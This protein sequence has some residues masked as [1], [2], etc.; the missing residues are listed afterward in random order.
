[1]NHDVFYFPQQELKKSLGDQLY[2]KH[3]KIIPLLLLIQYRLNS[4]FGNYNDKRLRIFEYDNFIFDL[5]SLLYNKTLTLAGYDNHDADK[6]YILL[7]R[8]IVNNSRYS[9]AYSWL[10]DNYDIAICDRRIATKKNL[11]N[12]S[13]KKNSGNYV[14]MRESIIGEGLANA[15]LNYQDY[16]SCGFQE[17]KSSLTELLAALE[18]QYMLRKKRIK[19]LLEK[20]NIE[21]FVTINQY[22]APDFILCDACNELGIITKQVEHH[23]YKYSDH[24]SSINKPVRLTFVNKHLVWDENDLVINKHNYTLL[25]AFNQNVEFVVAGS[26]ELIRGAITKSSNKAEY[27]TL[28]LSD[29]PTHDHELENQII[30]W[31]NVLFK[32]IKMLSDKLNIPVMIR[33]KPG[34]TLYREYDDI[35]FN[36]FGFTVSEST[37]E[38]LY[39]DILSSKLVISTP[40]SIVELCGYL[41][42]KVC[43]IDYPLLP[44]DSPD[45]VLMVPNI[46]L[47]E[48]ANIKLEEIDCRKEA[49]YFNFDILTEV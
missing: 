17:D 29:I 33:Y 47:K 42:I 44:A 28:M 45:G 18:T 3:I 8:T 20:S 1:M 39:P 35:I 43:T 11:M 48:V 5:P 16:T 9:N 12:K 32:Q 14:F 27:I 21:C 24:D 13:D 46:P 7:S 37:P 19:F 40:S 6:R 36:E 4:L 30:R 22:N 26:I 34:S 49:A 23:T 31:R 25:P 38:S 10:S 41:G 2:N 15:I